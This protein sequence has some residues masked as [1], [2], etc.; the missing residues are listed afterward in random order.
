VITIF[1]VVLLVFGLESLYRFMRS[2]RGGRSIARVSAANHRV[3]VSSTAVVA[4]LA[5]V[6]AFV[7][8]GLSGTLYMAMLLLA[9]EGLY[10]FLCRVSR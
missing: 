5:L 6:V 8:L 9:I 7:V 10:Q 4:I 1:F 2:N 3:T